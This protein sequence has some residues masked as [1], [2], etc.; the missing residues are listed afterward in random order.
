MASRIYSVSEFVTGLRE[1]LRHTIGVV[2]IQGEVTN[3]R[4][5]QSNLVFFELKDKESCL[6]CFGLSHEVRMKLEDG[7]ELQVTG[8]PSLFQKR[9][10]FHFRVMELRPVGA[11]ALQKALEEL[12]RRLEAEGVFRSERKRPL[13]RFPERIGLITSPDAAAY[14][15]VLRVLQNRWGG[16]RVLFFPVAVQGGGAARQIAQ[17]LRAAGQESLDAIILTRGGGSLEDL[18]SFNDEEVARAIFASPVPVV[19][20][21]GHERDWT[22]ADL[23]AD[24][25]AA[26]P[27][28]A[29]EL[30]VPDR[31]D[32]NAGID[33][34]VES[35]S[36]SFSHQLSRRE[37]DLTAQFSGLQRSLETRSL[38]LRS[39][40]DRFGRFNVLARQRLMNR[41]ADLRAAVQLLVRGI[42]S[43]VARNLVNLDQQSRLLGSLSPQAT[44]ERGY[45]I[46]RLA[47]QR[48]PLR[49]AGEVRPGAVLTTQLADGSLSST[50]TQHTHDD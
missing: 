31:R 35:L 44:L 19:T 25:R 36:A 40:L 28:N 48:A 24:V 34:M 20:G 39:L 1:V 26:T 38:R 4:A 3:Y 42:R 16:L 21:V 33:A 30:L 7:M 49:A 12:K 29:A 13:P 45:S 14:T 50:V 32:I 22:I 2:T 11:G 9:G 10:S 18:Q 47:G 46:T 43:S 37:A 15:D 23:V 17:A 8:Y 27:S 6:L 41:Q 5:Q